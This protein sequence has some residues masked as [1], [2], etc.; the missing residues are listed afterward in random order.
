[1]TEVA[2]YILFS[3]EKIDY[4]NKRYDRMLIRTGPIRLAVVMEFLSGTESRS[5]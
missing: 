4:K 3:L 1:V 2:D 5:R